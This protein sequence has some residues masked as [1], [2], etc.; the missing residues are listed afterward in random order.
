MN[1]NNLHIEASLL[2][3]IGCVR[4]CN[5]DSLLYVYPADNSRLEEKGV[6]A[7]VADGM[8][9]HQSGEI[10]SQIAVETINK[11]YY[12]S[13][14]PPNKALEE[15][16]LAANEWIYSTARTEPRFNGMGTTG[17]ALVIRDHHMWFAHVGDSR[18]YRI[19]SSAI[20]CL[21][22][23]HTLVRELFEAGII[24]AAAV[25]N[26]PDRNII[27]R[28]LGTHPHVEVD[29]AGPLSVQEGDHYILCS[30]GLYDLVGDEEILTNVTA[31]PI[32]IATHSLIALAKQRGGYDNISIAIV[33]CL[34][35]NCLQASL[36]IT[37]F[38]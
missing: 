22:K 34:A 37:R 23:D 26:H 9:G 20:E 19:R 14:K 27:T 28:S 10:A 5:E 1:E 3:D 12:Q 16:F 32:R 29:V 2:S 17:T 6:F 33:A 31:K 30:D 8:G 7:M 38:D 13:N 18:L 21:S 4:Q 24:D 36:A 25:A 35:A 15:A 11:I